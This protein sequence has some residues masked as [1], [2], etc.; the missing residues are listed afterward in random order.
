MKPTVKIISY[1]NAFFELESDC[2]EVEILQMATFTTLDRTRQGGKT[3]P[4][5]LQTSPNP[6]ST[7]RIKLTAEDL[8][9]YLYGYTPI[10]LV[11]PIQLQQRRRKASQL[12][13]GAS[14]KAFSCKYKHQ[15]CKYCL[16]SLITVPYRNET[17]HSF[18]QNDKEKF[19]AR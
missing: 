3:S 19:T 18:L 15:R 16:E 11:D 6:P 4:V 12:E 1:S 8:F 17:K 13:N 14:N 9:N 2:S 7:Q 5:Q 10:R